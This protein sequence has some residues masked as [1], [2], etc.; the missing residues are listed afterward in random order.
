MRTA[1]VDIYACTLF[2]SRLFEYRS[3]RGDMVVVRVEWC[4]CVQFYILMCAVVAAACV[5]R[6]C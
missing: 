5:S 2:R 3:G 4:V 1:H 6:S